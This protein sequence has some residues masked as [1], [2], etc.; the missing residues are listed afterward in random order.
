MLK[1]FSV[2]GLI[3]EF[4]SKIRLLE[5]TGIVIERDVSNLDVSKERIFELLKVQNSCLVGE[6]NEM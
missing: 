2:S 4:D 3:K 5:D 1:L 6:K